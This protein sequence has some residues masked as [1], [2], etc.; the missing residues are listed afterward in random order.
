MRDYD[1]IV[2]E[3]SSIADLVSVLWLVFTEAKAGNV[4]IPSEHVMQDALYAVETHIQRISEELG[5]FTAIRK[6]PG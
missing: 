5:E 3:L 2:A 6:S 1:D 4:G